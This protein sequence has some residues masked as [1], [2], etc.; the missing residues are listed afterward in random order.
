MWSESLEDLSTPRRQLNISRMY[1]FPVLHLRAGLLI[2][3]LD[4]FFS[5]SGKLFTV[6][7]PYHEV[8]D[9]GSVMVAGNAVYV[10]CT[11]DMTIVFFLYFPNICRIRFHKRG[12]NFL[13]GM[14]T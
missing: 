10:N 7:V 9:V 12:C 1:A 14:T 11:G 13:L 5:F 6:L 3:I 8:G 4:G 2:L